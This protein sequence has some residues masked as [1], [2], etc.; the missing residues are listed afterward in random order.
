[1][2]VRVNGEVII[3]CSHFESRG[4]EGGM[5]EKINRVNWGTCYYQP[6]QD[7][8]AKTLLTKNNKPERGITGSDEAIISDDYKGQHNLYES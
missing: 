3:M 5:E 1:M 7:R 6:I 4:T 2:K 8:R